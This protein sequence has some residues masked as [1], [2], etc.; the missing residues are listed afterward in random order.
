MRYALLVLLIC[1]GI[2]FDLGVYVAT[3]DDSF[4]SFDPLRPA[5]LLPIVAS[6]LDALKFQLRELDVQAFLDEFAAAYRERLG[7]ELPR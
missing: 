2:A 3:S 7:H 5:T 1:L 6:R 4:G